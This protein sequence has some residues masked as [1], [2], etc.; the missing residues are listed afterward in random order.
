M[1]INSKVA[2]ISLKT[3]KFAYRTYKITS[4]PGKLEQFFEKWMKRSEVLQKLKQ[5]TQGFDQSTWSTCPKQALKTCP[6]VARISKLTRVAWKA[7]KKATKKRTLVIFFVL[8]FDS[9]AHELRK[10]TRALSEEEVVDESTASFSL[11][12][13]NIDRHRQIL[14]RQL[15]VVTKRAFALILEQRPRCAEEMVKVQALTIDLERALESVR[16]ARFGLDRYKNHYKT[17]TTRVSVVSLQAQIIKTRSYSPTHGSSC[18]AFWWR[19]CSHE[20]AICLLLK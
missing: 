2:K 4:S 3:A 9:C 1:K 10:Y 19:F 6:D 16:S 12:Q 13:G 20:L 14:L 11:D 8:D 15:K 18:K 17:V 7:I 5:K